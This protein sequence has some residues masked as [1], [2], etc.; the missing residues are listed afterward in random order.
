MMWNNISVGLMHDA[1]SNCTRELLAIAGTL[2]AKQVQALADTEVS[3]LASLIATRTPACSPVF[4]ILSAAQQKAQRSRTNAGRTHRGHIRR[5]YCDTR[6][7]ITRAAA[8][9]RN[10]FAPHSLGLARK[11]TT[12][13]ATAQSLPISCWIW[14]LRDQVESPRKV[15]VRARGNWRGT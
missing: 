5:H 12:V 6:L 9:A 7:E 8:Y 10:G 2:N 3:L 15:H 14:Y 13:Q 1:A 11:T 4:N